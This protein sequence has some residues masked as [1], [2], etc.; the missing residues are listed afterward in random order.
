MG[1]TLKIGFS[2]KKH[3]VN[4]NA[5]KILEF[6][7]NNFKFDRFETVNINL[8]HKPDWFVSLNPSGS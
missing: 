3:T 4:F 5:L 2:S 1:T 8:K 6:T 7:K